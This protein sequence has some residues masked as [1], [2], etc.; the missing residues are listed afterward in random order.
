MRRAAIL[1]GLLAAPARAADPAPQPRLEERWLSLA[2]QDAPAG[3]WW[4]GPDERDTSG[5]DTLAEALAAVPGLIFTPAPGNGSAA[6]IVRHGRSQPGLQVGGGLLPGVSPLLAGLF[7]AD[8]LLVGPPGGLGSAAGD[9]SLSLRRPAEKLAGLGEFAAGAFGSRRGLARLD[10][11][12][13]KGVRLGLAG[14]IQHDLGWLRNTT[15]GEQLNRGLRSGVAG[16]LDIDLGPTLSVA[17]TSLYARSKA[18][19]LPGFACDPNAPANCDGRFA[20]TGQRGQAPRASWGPISVD[21]AAQPLGQRTALVQNALRIVQQGERLR[22]ELSGSWVRQTGDLG[23]DLADGR[24]LAALAVPAGLASG[25]YGLIARTVDETRAIE[26]TGEADLGM[27]TLRGGVGISSGSNH[28]NQADTLAGSVLADRRIVQ[29]RDS[30]HG[31]A[32]ARLEPGH[33]LALEAGLRVDRQTLN[34]AASDRRAGCAPCLALAGPARQVET[35]VTPEFAA[36]WRASPQ[37]LIFARSARSA[38]LPGWNLLARSTPELQLLPAETGWHHQAGVKA[39]LW[40]GR[41]RL[42]ASGFVARTRGLV[43]PLLGID[44]LAL[45]GVGAA[46][47]RQDMTNHGLD[48]VAHARPVDQLDLAAT[49]GWQQARWTGAVPAGA[50]GRPLYA[51]DTTA[52]LSAAWR[53]PLVGTGSVLIPRVAARWRSAMA[54]AG[55]PVLGLAD[56]VS[57]GGWQVAAALQMEIPDGGWL[58]SLECENCLD[59]TLTDG[60]VAGLP[61]LNPPRW[62]QIRFRR[63]F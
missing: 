30:N 28:R 41:L 5:A 38:R 13:S 18:G 25:G 63:R 46:S 3:L 48:V 34:L 22:V 47:Q 51:P 57:P 54:V 39:D 55:G 26:L 61:T 21:L 8:L 6:L 45:A 53:Q 7:D 32:Q 16:T 40:Q 59:Q 27:L 12:V 56:G 33:G 49:L 43:S 20:S 52:S 1:V 37:W 29:D 44:P 15:T 2:A 24:H 50:P 10:V 4:A 36:S 60:A 42:D 17:L 14:H 58:M 31:F 62:W 35:L 19:N 9:I 23:L 11:P